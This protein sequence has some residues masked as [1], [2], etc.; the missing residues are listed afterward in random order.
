[1]SHISDSEKSDGK[2]SEETGGDGRELRLVLIGRTGSGKSATGNTILGRGHF[3]SGLSASSVTQV[4]EQG[5]A[6][7]PDDEAETHRKV[8]VVD[9]PGFGDTR[10]DPGVVHTEMAKCVALSAPGP[11][12]FLLV[13][14]LGRYTDDEDRAARETLRLFGES[15]LRRHTVV[16]FT[17]GDDL[18]ECGGDLELF[19]RQNVPEALR[20]LLE[21]C[22]RRYHVLNNKNLKNREQVKELL[23]KVEKMVEE[24]GGQYYTSAMFQEAELAI[25]E[26]EER[27]M[28]SQGAADTEGAL[29]LSKRRRTDCEERAE[30]MWVKERSVEKWWLLKEGWQKWRDRERG[31]GRSGLKSLR[32]KA[33]LSPKVLQRVKVLVAAGAT[34][35]AV[36]AVCGAV[37]PLALAAGASVVSS[38]VAI[39][40][41]VAG[42]TAVAVG[43]AMG[44]VVGGANGVLVG[45]EAAAPGEA[46]LDTLEQVGLVG[47]TVVAGAAVVG[48]A[49]GV[50]AGLVGA[51][52]EGGAA[53]AGAETV[54][55]ANAAAAPQALGGAVVEGAATGNGLT[56]AAGTSGCLLTAVTELGRVAAGVVLAGGLVVKVVKE[57]T[58]SATGC[59]DRKSYEISW[60]K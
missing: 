29:V 4:C 10:A 13:I 17:R 52:M 26:E 58:R 35:F 53:I 34:G 15:A 16:V 19:L 45:A 42:K 27:L 5:G 38:S 20:S 28:L 41:G 60:N 31:R 23:R 54:G 55:I 21:I 24:N 32:T 46:A 49:L 39:T 18:E 8:L 2:R 11:H 12:A 51:G 43:A 25:R 57:K 48:G 14:Q 47:V 6:E 1:M 40:A 7:L 3:L 9:M 37:A 22:G 30:E 50:G 44:G 36:G 56:A 33:A 59:T